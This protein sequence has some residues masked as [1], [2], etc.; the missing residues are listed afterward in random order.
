MNLI[1]GYGKTILCKQPIVGKWY[2][3]IQC[4]I[5]RKYKV[6]SAGL[7]ESEYEM[8]VSSKELC[9]NCPCNYGKVSMYWTKK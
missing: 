2:D 5:S 9:S 1:Y 6:L 4:D 7:S 3:H 8:I